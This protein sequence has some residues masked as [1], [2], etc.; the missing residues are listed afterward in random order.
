MIAAALLS[1]IVWLNGRG[2]MERKTL[3]RRMKMRIRLS[4][5]EAFVPSDVVDLSGRACW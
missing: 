2:P 1:L 4:A 3:V 5:C